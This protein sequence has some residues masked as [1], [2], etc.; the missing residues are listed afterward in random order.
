MSDQSAEQAT[1]FIG[2]TVQVAIVSDDLH[3]GIDQL[4]KLGIGPF[5]VFKVTP[6][7]C[8]E[9]RY[10]GKPA[11]FGM[12]LAFTTAAN[13]MWEVIQPEAGP[14]IYQ[15]FLDAGHRGIN[16]VAVD[17]GDLTY[18]QRVAGLKAR[19]YREL[20]GGVAFNGDV[21]FGYWHNGDP[22]APIIEIFDFPEGFEPTPDE[23]Y[24]APAA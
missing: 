2:N 24:P 6:A 19:G 21:P 23:V 18:E 22:D 12:T 14:T 4:A 5:A 10:E 16:H 17:C 7:N 9:Q 13:M 15:D 11:Q 8:T 20:Q 3:K 1:P